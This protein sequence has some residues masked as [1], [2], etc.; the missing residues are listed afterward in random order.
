MP[1]NTMPV[2][3]GKIGTAGYWIKIWNEHVDAINTT[4]QWNELV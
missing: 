2:Q 1:E 3:K 4:N